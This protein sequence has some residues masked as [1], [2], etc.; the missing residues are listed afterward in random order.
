MRMRFPNRVGLKLLLIVALAALLRFWGL[1]VK[2]LWLDEILQLLHSRPDSV[3]EILKGVAQDRGAAPLDY[4][5][6]HV[7]IVNLKGA[8]EWTA[9]F[10]AALFGVLAVLLIYVLCQTLFN[11]QRLSLM[12]ALLLCFYP[13][14]HHYSQ[15]GRPYSLFLLLTLI[16]YLVLFRSLKRSSWH[17]WGT[18]SAVAVM[19][20][21]THAYAALVLFG[22][23]LFL[24]YHQ[25]L[26]HENWPAA[27]R[28]GACFLFCSVLAAVAYIPW[29]RYTFFNSKGDAPPGNSFRL[30]LEMIKGLGDGSYPLAIALILC[31]VAGIHHL[32]KTQ[33]FLECGALLIWVMTPF[34]LILGILNW[35]SYFFASRQLLFIAPALLILAAVG[36][37]YLKQK[38]ARRYFSPEIILILISVVV[39]ALHYRDKRDDLRAAGQFLKENAQ[40]S[41]V[42]ISPGLTYT[43]S[44]YFPDINDFSANSLPVQ[45]LSRA[46]SVSRILYVDSRFNKDHSGLNDLLTVMRKSEEVRFRGITVFCFSKS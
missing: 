26:K 17:I 46:P 45:D 16:L 5:I 38:I 23:L 2:Q 27:L 24:I 3:Q 36:A 10:H 9:R 7:F 25:V 42:I 32:R 22:Q 33:R 44:F 4:L 37:D 43:L 29:L 28:R 34:P 31:A 12:S 21:Y 1:G 30:L 20:F 39:I 41:D 11:N 15:E 6:Q 40:S 14:H 13:F 35:R 18:F 19:A 8:I